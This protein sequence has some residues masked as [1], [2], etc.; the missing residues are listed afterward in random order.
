MAA[1]SPE[2]LPK[3][4]RVLLVDD[5]QMLR[6]SLAKAISVHEDFIVVGEAADGIDAVEFARELRPDLI[7]MDV[8]MPK[9]NGIEAAKLLKIAIPGIQIVGLSASDSVEI[10]NAM[11]GAGADAFVSK[12]DP[13]EM[14][15]ALLRSLPTAC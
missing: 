1:A 7:V 5:H 15:M 8:S 12:N 14:L 13:I 4:T 10:S 11:L 2:T 3:P 6:Q 9:M